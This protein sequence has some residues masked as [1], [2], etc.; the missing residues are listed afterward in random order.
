MKLC[1][2][3]R[4][5]LRPLL[6]EKC[7]LRRNRLG[8]AIAGSTHNPWLPDQVRYDRVSRFAIGWGPLSQRCPIRI[9]PNRVDRPRGCERQYCLD[10][11]TCAPSQPRKYGVNSWL[12]A[13]PS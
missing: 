13:A 1:A 5:V 9:A 8:P 3:V 4:S 11:C 2:G 7:T 6:R 10:A 12:M